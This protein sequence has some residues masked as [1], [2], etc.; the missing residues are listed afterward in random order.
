ML[1]LYGET[2]GDVLTREDVRHLLVRTG[3]IE[4]GIFRP[5]G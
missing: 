2:Y 4:S 3:Q 5:Q 1:D